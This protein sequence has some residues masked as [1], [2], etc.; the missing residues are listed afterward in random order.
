MFED[1]LLERRFNKSHRKGATTISFAIQVLIIAALV[2]APMMFVEA[3]PSR[4][5]VTVL[6]APSPPPPPPPPAA[7]TPQVKVPKHKIES[8][9]L[10]N[11]EL[12][13]PSHIPKKIA[14]IKE[15]APPPPSLSGVVGGV[16]GGVPGGVLGGVI[17]GIVNSGS[18]PQLPKLVA[19][20]PRRV[21]IPQGV[22]EGLLIHKVKP[23]Y[24]EIAREARVQ[25]PVVLKAVIAKD[26]TVQHL[27]LVSGNPMLV[28]SAIDAVKEWRFRPYRLDGQPVEIETTI[29]INFHLG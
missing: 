13:A 14:M 17:G 11:G 5:L 7:E 3:L 22:S 18:R 6:V 25:G 1:S 29:T 28:A 19:A 23:L 26:G 8:E 24:P 12:R 2:I 16:P 27:Q 4:E 20:Q 21:R 15:S 10:D 9:V